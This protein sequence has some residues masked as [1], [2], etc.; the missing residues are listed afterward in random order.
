MKRLDYV[1]LAVG[2]YFQIRSMWDATQFAN[3]GNYT[4]AIY[5]MI[6]AAMFFAATVLVGVVIRKDKA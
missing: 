6:W 2:F 3:D 1:V 4:A 5:Y